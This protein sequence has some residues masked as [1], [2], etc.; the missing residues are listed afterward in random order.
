M[1]KKKPKLKKYPDGGSPTGV[2]SYTKGNTRYV[3]DLTDKGWFTNAPKSVNAVAPIESMLI[4]QGNHITGYTNKMGNATQYW[5]PN[6]NTWSSSTEEEYNRKG[7]DP[8][9]T[10]RFIPTFSQGGSLPKYYN[11]TGDPTGSYAD[12]QSAY[13]AANL[14]G[15]MMD[16]YGSAGGENAGMYGAEGQYDQGQ[17]SSGNN[18]GQYAATGMAA[19]LAGANYASVYNDPNATTSDKA[20]AGR[21]GVASVAGTVSPVVGG[22]IGMANTIA[23]PIKKN[24]ESMDSEGN[25]QNQRGAQAGAI[26]GNFLSPSTL[27]TTISEGKWSLNGKAY[28]DSLESDAKA[29]IPPLSIICLALAYFS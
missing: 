12:Q 20:T 10:N 13:N 2:Q 16:E 14:S 15:S 22:I 18:Y 19:G 9:N 5:V 11:G 7:F 4:P 23:A 28:T 1:K 21:N 3:K 24:A 6:G 29:K 17:G 26:V 27:A 8:I 25:L